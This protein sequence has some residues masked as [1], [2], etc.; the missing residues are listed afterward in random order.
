MKTLTSKD[1]ARILR[2]LHG[3]PKTGK[4]IADALGLSYP[5]TTQLLE[6]LARKQVIHSPCCAL[7]TQGRTVNLWALRPSETD[8]A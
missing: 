7:N 5:R 3:G 1:D 6:V 2:C 4:E 8:P